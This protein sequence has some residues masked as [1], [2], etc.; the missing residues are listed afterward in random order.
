MSADKVQFDIRGMTCAACVGRVEDG[1]RQTPGVLSASVNFA[2]EKAI[3]EYDGSL[4]NIQTLQDKVRDLGYTAFMDASGTDQKK[5]TVS[6]GGMTCAACVR[7]VENALKEVDGVKDVS[8]N[9]A[10]GR[11]T[12]IHD[13]RWAGLE[14]LAKTIKDA[15]YEFLG[16]LK[17]S[18]ADPIEA[19]RAAELREMKIKVT[20]GA[21]LSVII[22]FG[23]MQHWF[24]FL[25][26]IPHQVILWTMFVL[27][28]PAVFWVGSR[29]F[30]GAYKAARQKTSD[31]NTLV[32]VGAFSAYAYSAAA[33]FFPMLFAEAGL[34]PHVYYDGA[35]IIVTLILLGRYLEARAKGKTSAAIK[36]LI[37][38]KPKIAHLLQ[39]DTEKDIPVE[40]LQV[41]DV[42]QVRPGEKIPVDGVVLTGQSTIDESMLT[43][44]SLPV[45]KEPGQKV[46]AATLNTSGSF[47]MRA[48]GVGSDTMLAHIIRMV[49]E[50]QG[51]KAPIQRL[52]DKVASVFVPAVFIIAFITFGIWYFIPSEANFSRA[53]INFVSVLVIACP[54]AL[55]LATPTAIMVGTGLGAQSGILIKGGEALEKIHR[56]TTVVFDKTGTLTRGEPAVTNIVSAVGYDEKQILAVAATLEKTSEHPLAQAILKRAQALNINVAPADK[57]LALSGMG[58]KAQVKDKLCLIGNRML[59]QTEGVETKVLEKSA[60]KLVQEGKTVVYVVEER[61]VIGLIALADVPKDTAKQAVESLQ[62]KGLK[63]AMI[64]GDNTGTARAI[65]AQLGI[66]KV[67]AEVLPGSKADEIRKLQNEGEIVAMVGDGINDAPALAA[68]DVGIAIGAGTDVAIEA[69]DITLIRDD[70]MG[71]PQAINLSLATM[72]VIKQNLFW[73][74]IYNVIGIPIAAGALYPAFGILLNPEFAAAAMALSSVSVVSNS[75]R[76]KRIWKKGSN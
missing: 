10:T 67:L 27:T 69:G 13:I 50:A 64:T 15:G 56:L 11:A 63:V 60:G 24:S 16:E 48:T 26:F 41:N 3:V 55:G 36:K 74:F 72:R 45:A 70:L 21:I 28:A 43:G 19:A 46:F 37:G 53:L 35:A 59:M 66:E 52:A 23:S 44:E 4:V 20:C 17:D 39:G 49:E 1:L 25:H 9:L 31:M 22:F 51:S 75:L 76:L 33:T 18:S 42:V 8:V 34:A 61:R 58:A 68:A 65:A 47:T 32:A 7:R 5:I 57:F 30:V 73:A 14:A 2:T 71:V 38:L 6:V 62:H 12:V 40:D 29:F 54:C